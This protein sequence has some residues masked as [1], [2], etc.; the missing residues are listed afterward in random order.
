MTTTILKDSPKGGIVGRK[1]T[2]P[3]F[4]PTTLRR[5]FCLRLHDAA[6]GHT[7]AEIAKAVGVST[8]AVSK[9]FQGENCPD[10]DVLPKLAALLG[11][12][13]YRELLPPS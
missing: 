7:N 12:S 3:T 2:R 4:K 1:R 13:D 9:W 11:Y 5:K 6:I 8:D 10:Y